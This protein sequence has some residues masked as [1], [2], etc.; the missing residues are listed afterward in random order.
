M[1]MMM[2]KYK[3]FTFQDQVRSKLIVI[4]D[5]NNDY[6]NNTDDDNDD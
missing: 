1:I 6:E 5:D 3:S 4:D 2:L